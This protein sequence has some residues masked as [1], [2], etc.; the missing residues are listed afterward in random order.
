[1]ASRELPGLGLN[2]FWNLGEDGWNTGMD[3]NLLVLS[4]LVQG[5]VLSRVTALPGSPSEGDRYIVPTGSGG[6]SN[7]IAVYDDGAWV[8]LVPQ[9]GWLIYV[10]DVAEFRYWSGASWTV[11]PTGGGGG[12]GGATEF[13]ELTDVPADYTGQGEKLVA[14]KADESGLEFVDAPSGGGASYG[15]ASI[16]AQTGTSYTPV[17]GDKEGILITLSN[18][19]PI[20]FYL[21][22]DSEVAFPVGSVIEGHQLG[23]G[24]VSI[25]AGTGATV[26][27]R[28]GA[29]DSAGQYAF[30]AATKVAANI[31]SLTGDLV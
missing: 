11:L 30:F 10:I 17:L 26:N 27:S 9:Q 25:F 7:Q 8:Y 23:A 14:V 15:Y 6:T 20:A 16:N 18:A 5:S 19:S 12:G 28:G 31:W 29:T 22:Q 2:G 13:T 4:T 21:P 1:M 24:L 3:E